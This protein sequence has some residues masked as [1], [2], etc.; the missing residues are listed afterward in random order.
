ME[1]G[2]QI[3]SIRKSRHLTMEMLGKRAGYS[4]DYVWKVETGRERPSIKFLERVGEVL[5]AELVTTFRMEDGTQAFHIEQEGD[6]FPT[7]ELPDTPEAR[8]DYRRLMEFL[9]S[10]YSRPPD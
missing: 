10:K 4:K 6:E 7:G 9:R 2:E 5:D 3:R 8:E 1:I